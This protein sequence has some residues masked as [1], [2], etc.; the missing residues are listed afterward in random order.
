[1]TFRFLIW[2]NIDLLLTITDSH[3]VRHGVD[4]RGQIKF[5]TT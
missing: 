2:L 4:K 5:R 3:F 1:M